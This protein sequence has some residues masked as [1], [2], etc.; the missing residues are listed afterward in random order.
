MTAKYKFDDLLATSLKVFYSIL[1]YSLLI[2]YYFNFSSISFDS[3]LETYKVFINSSS[4]KI[5]PEASDNI[6]KIL[7]SVAYYLFLFSKNS[8]T[9]F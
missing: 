8:F 1:N 6:F 4:S 5:L 7:F 3:I 9:F 2:S